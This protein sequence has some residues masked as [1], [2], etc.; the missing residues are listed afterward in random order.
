MNIE[1]KK[2][3]SDKWF[4][5]LQEQICSTFEKLEMKAGSKKK[6]VA[7]TWKKEKNHEGGGKYKILK[8]GMVFDK[9]GVNKSTVSG[10]FSKKISCKN[11][12]GRERWKL[13]GFWYFCSS[14]YAKP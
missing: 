6:F 1:D 5:Y 3:F 9:V 4:S 7:T 14:S 8:D 2:E 10:K 11:F 13:L 12:R